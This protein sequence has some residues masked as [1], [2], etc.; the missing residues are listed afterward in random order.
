MQGGPAPAQD[1]QP[2]NSGANPYR[3][4]RDWAQLTLEGRPWGGSNGVAIDRDGK[5]V[6]ATDRCSPGIEPGCLGSKANPVHL[7]DPS[8]KEV[9]SF[10][11]GM[12]VWPHSVHV[13]RDGNVWVTD[14][15]VASADE[16]KK[17]PGEDKK[18]SVVVKFSPEGTVLMTLGT[19]GV[20]GNPPDALTDPNAVITDPANGD[21]YV[22]ESHTNVEDPN[23]VG[24]ISVF[25][26]NGKFLRIIGKTGTGPGEF[27]TP[28]AMVFDS[29]GRL[30]VADRHNHRI[31]IL[32]KDG[33]YVGEYRDFSR[34]SGLAIDRN[35]TIYVADSES[36]PQRHPGWLKGIRI[37]SLKDGKVTIFVP[38]HKNDASDG[39]MGEGID[40]DAA[41]NLYTAEAT[42]RGVTKY[43]KD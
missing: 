34:A 14:A 9:R 1:V 27:R 33:T 8:G 18:G 40:I 37:G 3:V 25:D 29:Q 4:I 16:L 17:F 12:F 30:I 42:V 35:D 38:P 20:R 15:R 7:F 32:T 22:S 28:H 5:S 23:L 11:G 41:G 13:D 6:W 31:Q 2:V 43:V 26:R 24:R 21:I 10:G 19:P 39:A 36:S